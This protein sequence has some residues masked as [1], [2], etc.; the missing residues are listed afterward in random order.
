MDEFEI[1]RL[2]T[3]IAVIVIAL[4]LWAMLIGGMVLL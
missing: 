3:W 1:S 2:G 4:A